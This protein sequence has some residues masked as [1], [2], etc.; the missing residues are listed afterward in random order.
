MGD[1]IPIIIIT[2]N[3]LTVL[4]ESLNSYYQNFGRGFTPVIHDN[5][6]S[7]P[8]M[9]AFLHRFEEQGGSVFYSKRV[10]REQD[11]NHVAETVD[12]WMRAHDSRYYVVTDPDIAFD[13]GCSDLLELYADLLDVQ[14]DIDVVGPMLRIDDIPEHYPLKQRVIER[15]V[16]QFWHKLPMEFT[17]RDRA[18]RYQHAL[19]DTTFGM[20]RRG[21]RFRRLSRGIRTYAPYWARHLDWY[22]DPGAMA[23]DQWYYLEHA[24][25]G[26]WG[27]ILL[28]EALS[29]GASNRRLGRLES[30]VSRF[31]LI[32]KLGS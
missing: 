24:T 2:C 11:L 23:E 14:E 21:Y 22:L 6:S 12:T 19:I 20:Y 30:I 10:G 4:R 31:P 7:Y 25:V 16:E 3:R 26:H 32:R 5:A 17:W 27:S 29:G 13:A 18:I 8:P 15:H 9:M 28:R 1:S